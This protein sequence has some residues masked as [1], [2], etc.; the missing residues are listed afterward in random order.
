VLSGKRTQHLALRDIEA[1]PGHMLFMPPRVLHGATLMTENVSL[2]FSFN[3]AFLRPELP[4]AA[5]LAWD[6]PA[7]LQAVPELLPFAGQ[8]QIS[9]CCTPKL[10]RRL[11]DIGNDLRS[12]HTSGRVG[13]LAYSR[14]QLSLMLLEV[15]SAFE[16]PLLTAAASTEKRL[17]NPNGLDEVFT[18]LRAHIA[19]PLTVDAVARSVHLSP[20]CLAARIKRITGKTF[21]EILIELRLL[22]AKE[23]LLYS[24]RRVSEIAYA[25]GFEDHSYF[26]R[27]FRA[28]MGLSPLEYRRRRSTEITEITDRGVVRTA[29]AGFVEPGNIIVMQDKFSD[30]GVGHA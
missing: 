3:L 7:T 28:L 2:F 30:V 15:V 25:C 5:E 1:G 14:A 23:Y 16:Q 12:R 17:T 27:R 11:S 19:M 10:L 18:F 4:E 20:S 8:S 21:G 29:D 13:T 24:D 22:R 26:S 6:Q 9:I